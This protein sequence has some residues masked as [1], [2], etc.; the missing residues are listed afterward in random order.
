MKKTWLLV[1]ILFLLLSSQA[2]AQDLKLVPEPKQLQKHDGTFV[3]TSKTRIVINTA[4]AD[5]DRTAAETL[6]E[7]IEE[8][9]RLRLKI[10][11]ARSVP[12]SGAIYLA[13]IGDD[14][15]LAPTLEA[16]KLAIDDKFDDEG[17]VLDSNKDRIIIAARTGSGVFYGAQT[18][19][20]LIHRGEHNQGSV[21]SVAIKDWP[22]MRWRGV[23][24]DISRGPVPT[25]DYMKKQIRTCAAYKLNL[26]ALYIEHVFDYQ[27][28]PLIG[29][30][31]GSVTAAEIEELVR[32]AKRYYVTILPEQQAFGHLHHVLK[33]E[34]YT[35]LA[36]TPHGHVLG[37]A[38][39]P[40]CVT[41]RWSAR[42]PG[43]R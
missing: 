36:E 12:K 25:L 42:A 11:M 28:R 7:E 20:Q 4:H 31:E 21:P 16:S 29:P 38:N 10:S 39:R 40:G 33:N 27:S 43:S 8:S 3:I 5:E 35:D 9:N 17:Y 1:L 41:H 6:V 18:L 13:R 30:K 26:F 23:H 2:S 37:Q 32:Y 15:H 34:L 22:T 19:R 14:K 24:D